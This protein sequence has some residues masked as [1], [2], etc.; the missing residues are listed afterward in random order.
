MKI[1]AFPIIA[2][3]AALLPIVKCAPGE[4]ATEEEDRSCE[5]KEKEAAEVGEKTVQN[6]NY[7]CERVKGSGDYEKKYYKD[8]TKCKY[9]DEQT[10]ECMDNLCQNPEYIKKM[11]EDKEKNQENKKEGNQNEEEKNKEGKKE[12]GKNED[13]KKKEEKK[14]EGKNEDEKNKEEKKEEGKKEDEQKDEKADE[15]EKEK[16]KGENEGQKEEVPEEKTTA[17]T[18]EP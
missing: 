8:G 13:E 11:K 5:K 6:C 16:N 9:T 3:V 1:Q 14:E 15:G 2:V 17:G 10:S 12:E 7:F 4:S 18:Q